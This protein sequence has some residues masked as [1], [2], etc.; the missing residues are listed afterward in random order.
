MPN[1]RVDVAVGH[2][3]GKAVDIHRIG[4][5]SYECTNVL[6]NTQCV[7]SRV[8]LLS[9]RRIAIKYHTSCKSPS[10]SSGP[11]QDYYYQDIIHFNVDTRDA[12]PEFRPRR[13]RSK[14][15]PYFQVETDS[16]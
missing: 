10:S 11:R 4:R 6:C 5:L 16:M 7:V 2:K 1:C 3:I 15:G 8:E 9:L 13:V 12:T 14:P